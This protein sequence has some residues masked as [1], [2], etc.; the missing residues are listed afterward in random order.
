MECVPGLR[1]RLKLSPKTGRMVFSVDVESVFD[2]AWLTLARMMTDD[3]VEEHRA[4]NH[5]G[6]VGVM[7]CCCH[8]GNYF[9]RRNNRQEYCD[10]EECQKARNAKNQREFRNRKRMAKA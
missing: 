3:P 9:I 1:L 6:M 4:G 5:E 8:C 2:I 7:M 10:K